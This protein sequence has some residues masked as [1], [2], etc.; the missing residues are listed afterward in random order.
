[1]KRTAL[2]LGLALGATMA[3]AQAPADVA[4]HKCEPKPEYPGRLGMTVETTRKLFDRNMKAYETC[5]KAYLE[6][7]KAVIKA[8]ETAASAAIDEYNGVMSAIRKEQEAARQ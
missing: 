8:N 3:F 6:E 2:A 4:K 5:M 1:M 7:R